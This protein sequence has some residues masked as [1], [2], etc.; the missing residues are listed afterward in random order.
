V[1][2]ELQR[3]HGV[4]VVHEKLTEAAAIQGKRRAAIEG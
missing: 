3:T 2:P 1:R 4:G